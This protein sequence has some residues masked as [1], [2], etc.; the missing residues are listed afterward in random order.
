MHLSQFTNP[1]RSSNLKWFLFITTWQLA[2]IVIFLHY[3]PIPSIIK[4][5]LLRLFGAKVGSNVII[6]AN[7]N[8]HDPRNL[9]IGSN[10][11]IGENVVVINHA[12]VKISSN[13]CISQSVTLC[14]SSHDYKS[15]SFDYCHHPI[16]IFDGCWVQANS[17][18]CPGTTMH[19]DSILTPCSVASGV[20]AESFIYQGNPARPIRRRVINA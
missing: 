3:I 11:W 1:H 20:L 7:V 10:S 2:K 8:I 17:F 18:V 14:S 13:V 15:Q 16:H 5:F 12:L 6:K 19:S 9:S 4:S